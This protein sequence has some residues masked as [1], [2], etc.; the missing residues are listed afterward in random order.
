M[1]A[2]AS[3]R[4]NVPGVEDMSTAEY[5]CPMHPEVTQDGPGRCP[6]CGMD[7]VRRDNRREM[8]PPMV[9]M[10]REHYTPYRWVQAAIAGLGVWLIAGALTFDLGSRA[11]FWSDVLS[12]LVTLG[13]ALLASGRTR[14]WA[15]WAVSAVGLWLL[16]A[17]L[18]FWASDPLVYL[19]DSLVGI[20]L[21]VFG[22][23]IPMG[24]QMPGED[25]PDGWSYNPSSWPQR[26]PI[27]VLATISYFAARHMAAYQLG[28]TAEAWDPFFGDG[29]RRVLESE[30][31]RAWPVSDAGLGA[32]TYAIELLMAFMGDKRRWRTMP[33]MVAL[34]GIVV[35][36]LGVVSIALVIMQPLAVG[37]W[38]TLC[39]LTAALMLF[40]IPLA[41][42]E[43]VAMVQYVRRERRRGQSAWRVFWL[44]G[45]ATD[46]A[47]IPAARSES[48]RPKG[49]AWGVTAHW[50]LL[51]SA[52]AGVWLMFSPAVLGAGGGLADSAHFVGAL[53]IVVSVIAVAEVGRPARFF[54]LPLAAWLVT[55]P[56]FLDGGGVGDRLNSVIV[57]VA[58]VLASLPL[59]RIR[60][61]YGS[62]DAALRWS[63]LHRRRHDTGAPWEQGM[64]AA[65]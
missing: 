19:N 50:P 60:E 53:V 37:A 54:N 51:L 22:F 48:W 30:V 52:T 14:G 35:I 33:W 59:G 56:W 42:D 46:R 40:M 31:S 36:P 1:L 18:I 13:L 25:V 64:S 15:S 26:A 23:L 8:A 65:R 29:T 41:L 10:A 17:P 58:V 57:G 45:E 61:R 5:T 62:F 43:V 20:M 4:P 55:A 24:M 28:Y 38:C 3:A 32:L 7:L 12:G 27:I 11:L 21:I 9:M 2:G 34:F 39:L 49:M 44:G 16:S 6:K 47:R 63:P